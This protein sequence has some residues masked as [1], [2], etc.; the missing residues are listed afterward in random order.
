MWAVVAASPSAMDNFN[1]VD[2]IV[3]VACPI[4]ARTSALLGILLP[5]LKQLP[6][7]P[8]RLYFQTFAHVL[9]GIFRIVGTFYRQLL[10]IYQV[11]IILFI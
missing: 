1:S 7:R 2:L 3:V 6:K 8:F 10:Y 4:P 11:F 9:L 5:Q